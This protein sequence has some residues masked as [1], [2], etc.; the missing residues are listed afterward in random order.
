MIDKE[1]VRYVARLAHLSLSEAEVDRLA[2]DLSSILDYVRKLE[3]LDTSAIEPTAHAVPLA[4]TL[5]DDAV[6]PGLPPERALQGAPEPLGGG[7]GVPK[8]V[9]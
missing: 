7:F 6:K 5:R 9:E 3:E 1:Q 8:I 2:H 4:T